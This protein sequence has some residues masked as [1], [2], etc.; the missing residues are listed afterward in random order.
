MKKILGLATC[1]ALLIAGAAQADTLTIGSK[2]YYNNIYIDINGAP[3]TEVG[4]GS[5][6]PAT[7]NGK[8]L[9]YMYCVDLYHDI[10]VPGTYANSSTSSTG[11]VNG[12]LINTA[13]KIAWLLDH[14][15]SDLSSASEIALQAAIWNVEYNGKVVLDKILTNST[16][17]NDY[18]TYLD[19]LNADSSNTGNIS[20]YLWITPGKIGD[21]STYQ[22]QVASVPEAGAL[23]LFGT[24][25]VGLVGYRRVRRMQ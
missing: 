15:G 7:W 24:G 5:I 12:N 18:K 6:G 20:N 25:L 13:G 19:A 8:Q 3:A 4:G 16:A 9:T 10:Y 21:A 23:L 14:Y 17:Y 2:Y 11:I 1:M 22:G